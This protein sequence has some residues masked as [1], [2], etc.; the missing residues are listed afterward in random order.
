[1]K[2]ELLL[3]Q[4]E[5]LNILKD[6]QLNGIIHPKYDLELQSSIQQGLSKKLVNQLTSFMKQPSAAQA[7]TSDLKVV[8]AKV[9]FTIS[10]ISY[11]YNTFYYIFHFSFSFLMNF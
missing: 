4:N 10:Q 11:F 5:L 8:S 6:D 2:E 1:M 9:K 3:L 7:S